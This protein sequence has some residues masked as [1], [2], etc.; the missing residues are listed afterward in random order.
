MKAKEV[1]KYLL[2]EEDRKK[3]LEAIVGKENA[4]AVDRELRMRV[5]NDAPMV[6]AMLAATKEFS[7]QLQELHGSL[8]ANIAAVIILVNL[9]HV[10]YREAVEKEREEAR[11]KVN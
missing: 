8:A 3:V 4:E 1:R 10:S 6:D 11:K 2:S 9:V 5:K 7:R